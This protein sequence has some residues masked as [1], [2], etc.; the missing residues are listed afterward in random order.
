M[1]ENARFVPTCIKENKLAF[2]G[3][4]LSKV[5][6]CQGCNLVAAFLA[7]ASSINACIWTRNTMN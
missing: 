2:L 1:T 5:S 3:E 4:I 7:W 6:N